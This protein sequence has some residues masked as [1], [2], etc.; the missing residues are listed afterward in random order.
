MLFIVYYIFL[1]V[2]YS[3]RRKNIT[4]NKFVG[5]LLNYFSD[6]IFELQKYYISGWQKKCERSS[7]TTKN[8][9]N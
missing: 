1:S 2:T 4:S 6:I 8:M 3:W 7:A 9:K 5:V